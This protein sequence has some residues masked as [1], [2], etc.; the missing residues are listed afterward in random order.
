MPEVTVQQKR[1]GNVI[2]TLVSLALSMF[3]SIRYLIV[4]HKHINEND[5][6]DVGLTPF[7]SNIFIIF[8]FWA[9][10]YIHQVLFVLQYLIPGPGEQRS[11]ESRSSRLNV[12]NVVGYH[13]TVF[14]F[15]TFF[16][17]YLFSRG[18][19]ILSELVVV[20]NFLNVLML[21]FVHKTYA[22]KDFPSFIVIHLPTAALPM[23]WLFYLLFW[24]GAVVFRASSGF[25]ARVLANIFIWNFLLV[26]M[27]FLVVFADWGTGLAGSFLTLGIGFG[28]LFTKVF[29]LQWI[30]AFIIS[31]LLFFFSLVTV[32]G[33]GTKASVV[34]DNTAERA[35]LLNEDNRV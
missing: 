7:T 19:Y 8:I 27:F 2:F 20:V 6:F 25:V 16:W 31:G 30:F 4:G 5:P 35:P 23:T 13:F 21:Y 24:N 12:A 10:L 32:A 22:V 33:L 28:Q 14:N 1:Y 26:P 29:S 15:L 18:H 9:I 34:T 11:G 17:S 3:G